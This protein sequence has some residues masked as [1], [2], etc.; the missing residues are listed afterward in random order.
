MKLKAGKSLRALRFAI[1]SAALCLAAPVA[2]QTTVLR[3]SNW[4]PR[5]IRSSGT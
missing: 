4:L 3:V 2:A 5:A 1:A